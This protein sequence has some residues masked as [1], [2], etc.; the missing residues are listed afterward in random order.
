MAIKASIVGFA[1][2]AFM[3][4]VLLFLTAVVVVRRLRQHRANA[5][6]SIG[7]TDQHW[8][9][10]LKQPTDPVSLSK[11]ST[12]AEAHLVVVQGKSISSISS[13]SSRMGVSEAGSDTCSRSPS[14]GNGSSLLNP[15]AAAQAPGDQVVVELPQPGPQP[16]KQHSNPSTP[17]GHSNPSTPAGQSQQASMQQETQAHCMVVVSSTPGVESYAAAAP[18]TTVACH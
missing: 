18:P 12:T 1:I 14:F 2:L 16:P 17:A 10:A 4:P 15:P 9:A 13:S 3:G 5:P 11:L 7:D 8:P 6:L